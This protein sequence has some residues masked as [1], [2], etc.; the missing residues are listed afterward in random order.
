MISKISSSDDLNVDHPLEDEIYGDSYRVG[1][2]RLVPEL[3]E[4]FPR[5]LCPEIG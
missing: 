3:P 4:V 1:E 5:Y 2:G